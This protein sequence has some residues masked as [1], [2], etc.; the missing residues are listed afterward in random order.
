MLKDMWSYMPWPKSLHWQDYGQ[1]NELAVALLKKISSSQKK[2]P[3]WKKARR[4]SP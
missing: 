3:V 1:C 2:F 4:N